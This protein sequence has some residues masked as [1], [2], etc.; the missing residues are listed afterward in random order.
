M[1]VKNRIYKTAEKLAA[2]V[3]VGLLCLLA[4]AWLGASQSVWA[5][6]RD[7]EWGRFQNSPENNGVTEVT[8]P[9]SYEEASLK[10]GKQMV[11]GYTISFTPPLI[12]D[13][14]L[15]TASNKHVY[16]INKD[17]G[18]ILKESVE[19]KLNVSYAMN[20]LTYDP[21][22]DQLYVPILNGRIACL[23]ADTLEEKWTSREYRYTQSLSPV[24][25]KDGGVYTGIWEKDDTDGVFFRL[26]AKTGQEVWSFRP[27][28]HGDPAHGF[29]WAGAYVNDRYVVVGSDDGTNNTFAEAG[30]YPENAI[31]YC[32][33]RE[34]GQVVD[35][36]TGVK[37]DIRSTIVYSGGKIYFVSKGGRVY[38]AKLNANGTFGSTSYIQ[39]KDTLGIDAMITSTPVVY[40]GRIY[41]GAA[42]S[43]GQFSADGGHVFAVIRDNESLLESS[44]IYKTQISGYPQAAPILSKAEGKTRLYFTFNAF[45]GGIYMLEDDASAT[46]NSHPEAQLLYRP[47]LTDQ[48]YCISP[49]C[50]DREGTIYFKNDSGC[51]MA[52]S[53]NKAWLDN[54]SVQCRS[55][56]VE[57]DTSFKK[58]TLQYN[59]KAPDDAT[60]LDVRLTAP[61]GMTATVNGQTYNGKVTVPVTEDMEPITVTVRKTVGSREYA[62]TYT[63]NVQTESNNANLAGMVINTSNTRPAIVDQNN[64]NTG[65][66]YDPAFDP[67]ITEYVSKTYGDTKKFLNLWMQT[68]D[69]QASIRVWPVANVGNIGSTQ[70]LTEEGYIASTDGRFPVYWV[71]GENSAEVDVEITSESG[72]VSK[73]YHVTL[74]RSKDHLDVGAIPL[75]ASPSSLTLYTAGKARSEEITVTYNKEDV[76]D[77]CTFQSTDVSVAT[78]D[79]GGSLFAA[80]EGTAEIWVNYPKLGLRSRV[81]VRV[82]KPKAEKPLFSLVQ[83]TYIREKTLTLAPATEG[84]EI[85]Y[86]IGI[87]GEDVQVPETNTGTEYKESIALTGVAGEAHTYEICAIAYSK[88]KAYSKSEPQRFTYTIDRTGEE[89]GTEP[90]LPDPAEVVEVR[91]SQTQLSQ[92]TS[93]S[94]V[95]AIAAEVQKV[96]AIVVDTGGTRHETAVDWD[97]SDLPYD[98]EDLQKT[99]FLVHGTAA[100]PQGLDTGGHTMRVSL[101]VSVAEGTVEAPT[102]S[103]KEGTY[104]KPQQV[105][106]TTGTKGA[107][108]AYTVT[109]TTGTQI[110]AQ[111][112]E[113][114]GIKGKKTAL[115][116]KAYAVR[117]GVRSKTMS[118]TLTIDR[119]SE[120]PK[121]VVPSLKQAE[122]N[123]AGKRITVKL[124]AVQAASSYIVQYRQAGTSSWKTVSAGTP[125]VVVKGLKAGGLYEV[126]GAARNAGGQSG[127]GSSAYCLLSKASLK[128]KAKKKSLKLSS[129][130]LRGVSGYRYRASLKASMEGAKVVNA[131]KPKAKIKGL[132]SKKTYYVQVAPIVKKGGKTYV[133][134]WVTKKK[135][136]K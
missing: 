62:R 28:E 121:P 93:G 69:P 111:P 126:R 2:T 130:K 133:G 1:Y 23:D 136:V 78:V 61:T 102:M 91:P 9:A 19:L 47:E 4:V 123:A 89:A 63:L 38:K 16:Q 104:K 31:V 51:M 36:I 116:V 82:E 110:Y 94:T 52:V 109:G 49:L 27:S 81:H 96:K 57:W 41:V 29:Y 34:T 106:L 100:L 44:L 43:G 108:I 98:P 39:L 48:Q 72:K 97:L 103:P 54:I 18:E 95:Q 46:A 66:G 76:T 37:G 45:P 114:E 8:L 127:Y 21:D 84:T 131:T 17:S 113:V 83:G 77:Q 35:R 53:V 87:D 58:G 10:W 124:G 24:T 120:M 11:Q 119:T 132:K 6:D 122:V 32:F 118:Y 92:F 5:A 73:V 13:G 112:F 90:P 135:K 75:K 3:V 86:N 50:C 79:A 128:V 107:S 60:A 105:S 70:R 25:Y 101:T 117:N 80:A 99:S 65:V 64:H 12:I 59:L 134:Q 42:G 74:V 14:C 129:K 22:N 33:D 68:S 125:S 88:S 85:R 7:V 56:E 115:V 71:Q 55:K 40:N 67:A 30:A 15:Y 20:P 26:D